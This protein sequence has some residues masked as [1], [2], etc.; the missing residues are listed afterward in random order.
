MSDQ[1]HI[2]P[3]LQRDIEAVSARYRAAD[4]DA[5]PAALDDAIRAAARR[6]VGA[7]PL[8]MNKSW[9]APWTTPLAAAAMVVVTVSIGLLAVREKPEFAPPLEEVTEAQTAA[10]SESPAKAKSTAAMDMNRDATNTR[11]QPFEKR[12]ATTM[13]EKKSRA[14]ELDAAASGIIQPPSA[15]N[16]PAMQAAPMA[17][18]A[19]PAPAPMRGRQDIDQARRFNGGAAA[20]PATTAKLADER[21]EKEADKGTA[22]GQVGASSESSMSVNAGPPTVVAR[23]AD[24]LKASPDIEPPQHWIERIRLLRAQ[25]KTKDADDALKKF[26]AQYPDYLLPADLAPQR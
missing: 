24:T 21:K 10:P 25:G 3:E 20:E 26:G 12:E 22:S 23:K 18:P 6:A 5:P 19:A 7:R 17:F 1:N 4:D 9:I 16:A 13:L 11:S 15:V 2:D 8:P 14:P